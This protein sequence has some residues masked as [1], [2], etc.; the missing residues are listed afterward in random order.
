MEW[1]N[2]LTIEWRLRF[3]ILFYFSTK[4]GSKLHYKPGLTC[5]K[6]TFSSQILT[7]QLASSVRQNDEIEQRKL[8]RHDPIQKLRPRLPL[9]PRG[10]FQLPMPRKFIVNLGFILEIECNRLISRQFHH[11]H[12]ILF[13]DSTIFF[14]YYYPFR[15]F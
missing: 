3:I 10:G 2:F 13:M 15:G 6:A 8:R 4:L 1:R 11:R 7:K 14:V 9:L 5:N 12:L